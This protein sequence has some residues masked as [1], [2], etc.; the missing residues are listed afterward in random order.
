MAAIEPVVAFSRY[1][2]MPSRETFSIK[3]IRNFVDRYMA[4]SCCSVDPFARDQ[5]ATWTNDLDMATKADH[6]MDAED[7]LKRLHGRGV[8]ADLV[9]FDPPYSPR[10]ISDCYRSVGLEVGRLDTQSARLYRRVRDAINPLVQAGGV[11]LSF[12]WHSNGMGSKRGYRLEEILLVAHGGAHNDT[13][14]IAERKV[15]A[16]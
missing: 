8:A 11:V 6:H 14:G 4:R 2:A 3:P 7:F 9:I 12:G 16:E 10:Q 5:R 1:F 13:I 15:A